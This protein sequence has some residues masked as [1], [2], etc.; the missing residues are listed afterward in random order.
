MSAKVRLIALPKGVTS[1]TKP[2]SI[3]YMPREFLD[4]LRIEAARRRAYTETVLLEA[5]AIGLRAL[6]KQKVEW[7][8]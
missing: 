1:D 5:V 7:D 3:R 8:G 4:H 2:Y 6:R